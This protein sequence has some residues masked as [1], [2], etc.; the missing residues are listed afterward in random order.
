MDELFISGKFVKGLAPAAD[1]WNTGPDT[2]VV[3]LRNHDKLLAIVHQEG[4]T[5]GCAAIT[6]KACTDNAKAGATAIPFLYRV[7]ASGAGALGDA[8]GAVVQATSSGFVTTAATDRLYLIFVKGSDIQAIGG[9]VYLTL[10]E[11]VNDPV[12]AS[13]DFLLFDGRYEGVS[14]PTVIA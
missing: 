6:V 12:N 11:S 3:T 1:R 13:V 9:F 5:T 10:T 4:G 7:G 2:D 14:Q 8:M